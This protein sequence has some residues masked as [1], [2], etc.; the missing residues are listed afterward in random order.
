MLFSPPGEPCKDRPRGPRL[1]DRK[2]FGERHGKLRGGSRRSLGIFCHRREDLLHERRVGGG[3][4]V[5]KLDRVE[6]NPAGEA[7]SKHTADLVDFAD[8]PE[9]PWR[10]PM[11][12]IAE[13][14]RLRIDRELAHPLAERVEHQPLERLELRALWQQDAAPLRR[15][16]AR[17]HGL[18]CE[19]GD[20]GRIDELRDGQFGRVGPQQQSKVAALGRPAE[21]GPTGHRIGR[22][23][24][25]P[26]GGKAREHPLG[27]PP[28]RAGRREVVK[29][30]GPVGLHDH[31]LHEHDGRPRR[32]DGEARGGER[33]GCEVVAEG[34][35]RRGPQV[36]DGRAGKRHRVDPL[37]CDAAARCD[38]P[39]W[40]PWLSCD[41]FRDRL[42][43]SG[44]AAGQT[45]SGVPLDGT[46]RSGNPLFYCQ[47]FACRPLT[48]HR[49]PRVPL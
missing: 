32:G 19:A 17:L 21:S 25:H 42:D 5:Q 47:P 44:R 2:A 40:R 28:V 26:N 49:L 18:K 14:V 4:G 22:D 7:A 48:F 1:A 39:H 37:P 10:G 41:G 46:I 3:V 35:R 8:R 11:R 15:R 38:E 31:L 27:E 45:D 33:G 12:R 13:H 20:V 43:Q 29:R 16:E 36:E 6:R 24:R 30:S 9:E 23:A 34:P